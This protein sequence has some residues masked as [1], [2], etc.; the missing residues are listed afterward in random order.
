MRFTGLPARLKNV[1]WRPAH[2]INE[3]R[4]QAQQ[5]PPQVLPL[6]AERTPHP[7]PAD[8]PDSVNPRKSN[9]QH[10]V[11]RINRIAAHT[12]AKTY[13]EIGVSRGLTFRNVQI[14]RK[15]GVDP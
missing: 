2:P 1:L 13:L 8:R 12:G 5:Q 11:R 7:I 10:S 6:S 9:Q 14:T 15:V 3:E 4:G